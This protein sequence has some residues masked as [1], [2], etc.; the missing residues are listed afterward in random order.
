[1]PSP[2][3][4]KVIEGKKLGWDGLLYDSRD[5]AEQTAATYQRDNFETRVVEHDSKYLVYT[6]RV[7]K[8][9]VAAS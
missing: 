7:V 5:V 4:T 8:Q 3:T 9:A 6:R 1:M 2:A